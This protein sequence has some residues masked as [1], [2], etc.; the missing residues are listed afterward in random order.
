MEKPAKVVLGKFERMYTYVNYKYSCVYLL[1]FLIFIL[2]TLSVGSWTYHGIMTG[3]IAEGFLHLGT[4]T[5]GFFLYW[6][7]RHILLDIHGQIVPEILFDEVKKFL[8]KNEKFILILASKEKESMS[9]EDWRELN[10]RFYYC[11]I[12]LQ[13]KRNVNQEKQ[14]SK[15]LKESIIGKEKEIAGFENEFGI[16]GEK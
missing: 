12:Y 11:R 10:R 13:N 1:L 15:S 6:A 5:T 2:A 8:T 14:G 9:V 7:F 16:G 3:T 4:L